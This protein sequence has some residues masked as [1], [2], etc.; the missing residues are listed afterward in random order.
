MAIYRWIGSGNTGSTSANIFNWNHAP[1]WRRRFEVSPSKYIWAYNGIV[2]GPGDEVYFGYSGINNPGLSGSFT[3]L[4]KTKSPCL[5]GGF[6][7]S[8]AG[9]TWSGAGF[10]AYGTTFSSS[11][12]SFNVVN[13]SFTDTTLDL[14]YGENDFGFDNIPIGG[15]L[16]SGIDYVSNLEWVAKYYPNMGVSVQ[17]TPLGFTASVNASYDS[18]W[19][20]LTIK[21]NQVGIV[22]YGFY[23]D[24]GDISLNFVTSYISLG[25]S[26]GI[27]VA[28]SADVFSS[29]DIELSGGAF[30]FIKN[31]KFLDFKLNGS[32][33][34]TY[35]PQYPRFTLSNTFV[36]DL[37]LNGWGTNVIEDSVKFIDIDIDNYET[38]QFVDMLPIAGFGLTAAGHGV[39]LPSLTQVLGSGSVTAVNAV[40]YPGNTANTNSRKSKIIFDRNYMPLYHTSHA[41]ATGGVV[42]KS[43]EHWNSLSFA[44]EQQDRDYFVNIENTIGR[45]M[46]NKSVSIGNINFTLNGSQIE[47][48]TTQLLLGSPAGVTS[49]DVGQIIVKNSQPMNDH[50][51]SVLKLDGIV[52][53]NEV[54][55]GNYTMMNTV[56]RN[57]TTNKIQVGEVRL[58]PLSTLDLSGSKDYHYFGV[59]NSSGVCG[60]IMASQPGDPVNSEI[61]PSE[62]TGRI[63]FPKNG[64]IRLFNVNTGKGGSIQIPVAGDVADIAQVSGVNKK[65]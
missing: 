62:T 29:K 8:A 55:L 15:G 59:R 57:S 39:N 22:N 35:Y 9:G 58:A 27:A 64:S 53:V 36:E 63:V 6:V 24:P 1:N 52:N 54:Y 49:V 46:K 23:E 12:Q 4:E 51:V 21:T 13:N 2:P 56:P 65:G 28:T 17:L 10:T 25:T 26:G 30:R 18:T 7:G 42:T 40:I 11:L 47:P 38:A 48:Y 3:T 61:Y 50:F 5:F 37:R 19:D 31:L 20:A 43:A 41:S 32:T 34:D 14:Q 45:W 16:S 60:G 33:V 44:H